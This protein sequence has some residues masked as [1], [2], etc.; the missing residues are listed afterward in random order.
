MDKLITELNDEAYYLSDLERIKPEHRKREF[1]AIR[2]ALKQA[3][4]G[5]EKEIEY[6]YD[7]KPELKD[8]S[9]KI[10]FSHCQNSV[11]VMVHPRSEVG[12]DIEVP[13]QKLEKIHT[14]FLGKS[15]LEEYRK[16]N[17]L[18]YLRVVWSVKEALYK[19]IGETAYNFAEQL[20]I[21]PFHIKK[22]GQLEVVHVDTQKKY[23]VNYL[24]A[25]T[26]T[27]AYCIDNA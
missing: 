11:A 3:L 14:R 26:Y 19:I 18:D 5:I 7:G 15:E 17:S 13:T 1:L 4:G 6:T 20:Q 2:V 12:I 27:L 22:K 25:S 16:T 23:Q 21:L 10:S 24:L 8:G 9:N